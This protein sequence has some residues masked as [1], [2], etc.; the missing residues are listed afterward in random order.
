MMM[1]VMTSVSL[2]MSSPGESRSRS[3]RDTPETL[4]ITYYS[5]R[6]VSVGT[7]KTI[8]PNILIYRSEGQRGG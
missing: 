6:V 4:D 7:R 5:Q 3:G 8:P 2:A 1:T